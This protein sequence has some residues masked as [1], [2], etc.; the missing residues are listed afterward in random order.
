MI[1]LF[2]ALFFLFP[3]LLIFLMK[4]TGLKILEISMPQFVI[5]SLFVF[6]YIGIFPLFMYWDQYRFD[7]GVTDRNILLKVLFFSLLSILFVYLGALFS[8]SLLGIKKPIDENTYYINSNELSFLYL[9]LLIVFFVLILYLSKISNLALFALFNDEGVSVKRLR[10]DMGNDFQNYHWYKLIIHDLANVIA[11]SIFAAYLKSRNIKHLLICIITIMVNVFVAVMATEKAP[12]IFFIIGL[13]LVNIIVINNSKY[14]I[15]KL[16]FLTSFILCMLV[17]LYVVFMKFSDFSSAFSAVISRSFSG[18]IQ[19][20]YHYLEIFP[21]YQDFLLG[22]S[23][24]NPG[25]ILPHEPYRLT[26]EVMNW[27][28]PNLIDEGII[29]TMPT[30]FWGEAYVNFGL[31]GVVF[32]AFHI[33]MILYLIDYLFSYLRNTPLKIGLYVWCLLHYKNLSVTGV[34]SFV[35]DFY[36]ILIM[37]YFACVYFLSHNLVFKCKKELNG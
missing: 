28:F 36:L 37:A 20:A 26:R 2:S 14:P 9:T 5:V 25:G 12:I 15:K 23:F 33:G 13:F 27:V 32:F 11:F 7:V 29:G 24:P 34:F 1:I 19:P 10:S 30:V 17:I 22:K 4:L 6:S 31:I 21:N 3:A 18:S 8:R 35:F 16:L